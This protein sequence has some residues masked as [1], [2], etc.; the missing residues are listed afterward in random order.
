MHIARFAAGPDGRSCF[1]DVEIHHPI[2]IHA[3]EDNEL[4]ASVA[5][6]SP[7]VQLIILPAGLDVGLHPVPRRQLVFVLEGQLAV[8]TP[9][10]EIRHFAKGDVFLADDADT[11]G[12]TTQT[13]R[14]PV[15]LVYVPLQQGDTFSS[16]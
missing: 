14:G 13:V 8:G 5:L 3:A 4:A 11:D 2:T 16:G 6:E 1:S 15:H 7:A 12:H 10:G 9:D